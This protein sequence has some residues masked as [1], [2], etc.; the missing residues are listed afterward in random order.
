[1][2][3]SLSFGYITFVKE[4]LFFYLLSTLKSTSSLP[5]CFKL[6][7]KLLETRELREDEVSMRIIGGD[8]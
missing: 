7:K 1:M 3:G 8:F 2:V 5:A 4:S 6:P